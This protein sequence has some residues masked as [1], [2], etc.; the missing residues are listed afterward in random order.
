MDE[1]GAMI[2]SLDEENLENGDQTEGLGFAWIPFL[3]ALIPGL[4]AGVVGLFK[5]KA[6]TLTD[7]QL[8]M[9]A[10]LP[11]KYQQAAVQ[12]LEASSNM[13]TAFNSIYQKYYAMAVADK[14][15]KNTIILIAGGGVAL[16]V[17]LLLL[18]KKKRR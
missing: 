11:A 16:V 12:E 6:P 2:Y 3:A 13:Q 5:K 9:L 8:K 15:K 18:K 14:K 4:V 1:R 7:A 17:V 10:S